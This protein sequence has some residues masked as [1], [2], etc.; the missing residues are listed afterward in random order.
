MFDG[1]AVWQLIALGMIIG[2]GIGFILATVLAVI[3]VKLFMKQDIPWYIPSV[4][5]QHFLA[6]TQG[7]LEQG[8]KFGTPEFFDCV[9][10]CLQSSHK[11]PQR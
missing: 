7:C 1:W 2:F 4:K 3:I 5:E 10:K 9:Q 6:C 11:E 8:L